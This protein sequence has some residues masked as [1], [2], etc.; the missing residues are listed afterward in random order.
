MFIVDETPPCRVPVSIAFTCTPS[1]E[2]VVG[3]PP[4]V[5][6]VKKK[7]YQALAKEGSEISAET[8]RACA[9]LGQKL[10]DHDKMV[11]DDIKYS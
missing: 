4:M 7:K 9:H 1:N 11:I 3:A 6:Q 8:F 5:K 10:P 2:L